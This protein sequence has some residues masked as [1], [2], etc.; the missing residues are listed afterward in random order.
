MY[1]L[2]FPHD[3]VIALLTNENGTPSDF[4]P[5]EFRSCPDKTDVD[6]NMNS[7]VF[8]TSNYRQQCH[9]KSS[10]YLFC[11]FANFDKIGAEG[12]IPPLPV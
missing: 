2:E 3:E 12:K 1:T 6:I 9:A 4:S 8:E 11:K 10:F 5:V 7:T